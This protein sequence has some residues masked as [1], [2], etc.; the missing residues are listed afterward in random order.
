MESRRIGIILLT[1]NSSSRLY[2]IEVCSMSY[3]VNIKMNN[4]NISKDYPKDRASTAM[5]TELSK[6]LESSRRPI[7]LQ[8]QVHFYGSLN[9]YNIGLGLV[10]LLM[11]MLWV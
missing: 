11:R 5:R 6:N 7:Y 10:N 2:S 3:A 9:P 4:N 1:F 8:I